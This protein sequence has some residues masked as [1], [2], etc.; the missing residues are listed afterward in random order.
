MK[1]EISDGYG[2]ALSPLEEDLI[3][4]EG[5]L[6]A[7]AANA[8]NGVRDP[9]FPDVL[10]EGRITFWQNHESLPDDE[11]RIRYS[12]HR[13][14]QRM[15]HIATRDEIL[16]GQASRAGRP[17]VKVVAHLDKPVTPQGDVTLG[18]LLGIAAS[19]EGVEMAYHHGEIQQAI[20]ALDPEHREYVVL[21]FW[22]GWTDSEIARH[23]GVSTSGM[24][25][26]WVRRIRPTLVEHLGHLVG[27]S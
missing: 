15:Q 19:I 8:V 23:L 9:R 25:N 18:D 26:R 7:M 22:G 17:E 16:T 1:G 2:D 4:R 12:M 20:N 21:R 27:A 14:R 6:R 13:A 24:H 11:N 5:V 3:D 10:Q